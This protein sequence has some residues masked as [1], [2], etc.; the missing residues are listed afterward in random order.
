MTQDHASSP[1]DVSHEDCLSAA[2]ALSRTSGDTFVWDV[3]DGWQQGRGAWGG[4]VVGAQL[5]AVQMMMAESPFG[6]DA[7]RALRTV[8]SQIFA[9]VPAEPVEIAVSVLRRGSAMT[10]FATVIRDSKGE[11]LATSTVIAGLARAAELATDSWPQI[12]APEM[13]AWG[14]VPVAPLGPPLAPDFMG[15][16]E[17][18]PC[19]GMPVSQSSAATTGWVRPRCTQ[20]WEAWSLVAMVD[21]W[22]PASLPTLSSMRPMATVNFSA[23]LL[24]DPGTVAPDAP[25]FH[26]G[27]VTGVVE[28]YTT[29]IRRLWTADGRCAVDNHQSIAVIK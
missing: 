13:P 16:L 6:D 3:R 23:S 19:T 2:C 4:A 21:A 12:T 26:E 5:R 10:T 24:V 11:A 17:I 22:W 8:T 20:P 1:D 28:G 25:L 27:F 18:R 15:H 9:P 7:A 29:E 14:S